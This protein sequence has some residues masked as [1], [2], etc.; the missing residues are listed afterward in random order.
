MKQKRCINL[1]TEF[2]KSLKKQMQENK[3]FQENLKL[4]SNESNRIKESDTM[5]KAREAMKESSKLV[6][7]V[8]KVLENLSESEIVK[9]SGKV[10]METGRKVGQVA[11]PILN[12]KAAKVV[13]K[14]VDSVKR[15]ILDSSSNAY[16][17]EY[18][19][20]ELRDK[21]RL[22]STP[23]FKQQR[24]VAPD[25]NAGQNIVLHKSSKM[26]NAWN[27]FKQ[28]STIGQ[29]LSSVKRGV[30]ESDHPIFEFIRS[31]REKTRINETE[32]AKVVKFIK[33]V[34]PTFRKDL[35]LKEMTQYIIPDVVELVLMEDERGIM[36]WC[37]ERALAKL[38][39]GFE[40]S[41]TQRLIPDSKLLDIRKVDIRQMTLLDDELPVIL[42]GF[43]THEILVYKNKKGQVVLGSEDS[44]QT[45]HYVIAFTK[46]QL[47]ESDAQVDPKTNGWVIID[48]HRAQ[49]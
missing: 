38:K 46:K 21:E 34:D 8:S 14:N 24:I 35:F 18:K 26:A 11:D 12:T 4:I 32:E 10:I 9:T 30:E 22:L 49:F 25:E 43:S 5:T 40:A 13:A 41:K 20:K 44:I 28:E 2:S 36:P 42:I 3:E 27:K 23:V 16:F 29:T 45:A 47:L 37:S 17:A 15:E 1:M 39:V 31:W 33:S 19:P 48:W 7:D 6:K